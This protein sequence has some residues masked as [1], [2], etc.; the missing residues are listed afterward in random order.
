M[1]TG[2]CVSISQLYEMLLAREEGGLE[3]VSAGEE[4]RNAENDKEKGPWMRWI[5]D[6]EGLNSTPNVTLV[7]SWEL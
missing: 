6:L 5:S 7:E 3:L 2:V 1:E 4:A